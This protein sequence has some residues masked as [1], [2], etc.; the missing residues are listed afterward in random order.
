[1]NLKLFSNQECNRFYSSNNLLQRGIIDSQICAGDF[2]RAKDTCQ[3][4]QDYYFK[5]FL[6]NISIDQ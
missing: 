2:N 4:K 1:M 5:L 3:V 6:K